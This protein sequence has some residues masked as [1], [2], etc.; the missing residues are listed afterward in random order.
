VVSTL[1]AA[2]NISTTQGLFNQINNAT[3]IS[4]FTSLPQDITLNTL[5]SFTW[6]STSVV[7]VSTISTFILDVRSTISGPGI[8]N[9]SSVSTVAIAGPGLSP[10]RV[11]TIANTPAVN[12]GNGAGTGGGFS[13]VVGI[14][15]PYSSISSYVAV[16]SILNLNP[17]PI[18][19]VENLSGNE[20]CIHS[21]TDLTGQLLSAMAFGQS[22]R[23]SS[24]GA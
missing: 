11:S 7:N 20:F 12:Q 9:L 14:S 24:F 3:P 10:F 8:M 21:P 23:I 4:S 18:V 5:T 13:S 19:W 22:E 2:T 1:T 16:V 6:A 17:P 15:F